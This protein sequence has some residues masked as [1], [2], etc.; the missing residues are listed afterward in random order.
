MYVIF[1]EAHHRGQA[2]VAIR[3]DYHTDLIAAVRAHGGIWSATKKCWYIV[4]RER[5]LPQLLKSLQ[6]NRK[7]RFEIRIGTTLLEKIDSS[8][9]PRLQENGE[10]APIDSEE[11]MPSVE[12]MHMTRRNRVTKTEYV[13]QQGMYWIFRIAYHT[14]RFEQLSK[15]KGVHWHR[16]QGVFFARIHHIVKERIEA[17]LEEPNFFPTIPEKPDD[18][19]E[20]H[21]IRLRPYPENK[22]L[23]AVYYNAP[24]GLIAQLRRIAGSRYHKGEHCYLLPAVPSLMTPLEEWSH[25]FRCP[26]IVEL[27]EGYLDNKNRYSRKS[28]ALTQ[29]VELLRNQMSSQHAP[30]VEQLMDYML[31]R[32]YSHNTIRTYTSAFI[33]YLRE[34]ALD[35]PD[36]LRQRDVVI[37][38][39]K[40]MQRGLS[41]STG[42][43]LVNVLKFYFREVLGR[44]SAE[45]KLP[46]PKKEKKLPVVLTAEE[47]QRIFAA[48]HNPKH[49]LLL[50]LGYG[51]GLRLSELVHLEWRDIQFE[52]HQIMVRSGKGNKDRRVM[53]PYVLLEAL[54]HYKLAQDSSTYVFQGQYA[55]EPYSPR[56][57][58]AVMGQA[59]K[60]AGLEKRATVHTLRH[61][62]ATHLL[63]HGTDLRYIQT[64]LGH[65]SVKTTMIY[66]HVQPSKMKKL[67]SPLDFMPNLSSEK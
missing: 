22:R 1:E 15:I 7:H 67:V 40:M 55:G 10:I 60:R 34:S 19:E 11:R 26:L 30:Y 2:I 20:M 51:S 57:V 8:Q 50:L 46:R 44:E 58:Q 16:R 32:N 54:R 6:C 36:E 33:H 63:E 48:V 47:C 56:S 17:I 31:A 49:R 14:K 24:S 38:L 37:H 29:A 21:Y 42:H 64:L 13:G 9:E 12:S 18:E 45:I 62:F 41:S 23:V 28:D 35:R 4:D 43:T 27:P 5:W 59:V 61:S 52:E 65:S 3:F 53:L 39:G 66:T 25:L